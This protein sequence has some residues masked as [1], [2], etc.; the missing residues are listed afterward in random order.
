ME[1]GGL[2][3]VAVILILREVR[4]FIAG[5]GTAN[6][7]AMRSKVLNELEFIEKKVDRLENTI[8]EL[9]REVRSRPPGP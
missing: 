1:S 9:V 5:L 6:P 3:V 8:N 7:E 4:S 2:I